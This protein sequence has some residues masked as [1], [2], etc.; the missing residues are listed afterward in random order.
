MKGFR[1][2]PLID[3]NRQINKNQKEKLDHLNLEPLPQTMLHTFHDAGT[4]LSHLTTAESVDLCNLPCSTLTVRSSG[5]AVTYRFNRPRCDQ[6]RACKRV[7]EH[8][9][10]EYFYLADADLLDESF[11]LVVPW[12][13]AKLH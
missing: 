13:Q 4:P 2:N 9:I 10:E 1:W 11:R 6:A 3:K 12:C 8:H 5:R 7:S